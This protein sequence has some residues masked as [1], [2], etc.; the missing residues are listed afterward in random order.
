[1]ILGQ[2][3]RLRPIEKD[4]LPRFVR[5]FSDP[6]VRALIGKHLP[7]GQVQEERWFDRNLSA[8]NEQTW[9]IDLQPE[10]AV[11]PWQHVGSCGFHTIDWLN[12]KG[13]V[14]IILGAK[15]YWGKGYGTDALQTL[16]AWGFY[17][18]NLNRVELR[19]FA[20]NTRAIRSY[21]KVGFMLEGRQRQA[22]FKNGTYQDELVMGVLRSDWARAVS[23]TTADPTD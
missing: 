3:T 6:E 14:G 20:N 16:V 11:G 12:R 1:M 17:T 19:V 4:D 8:G 15:E 23:D 22:I 7:V 13:E 9:A 2:K 18:L 21:E 5:W 10:M